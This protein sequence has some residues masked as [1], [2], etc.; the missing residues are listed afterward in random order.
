MATAW[1]S[2]SRSGPQ[3]GGLYDLRPVLSELRGHRSR[4]AH[5]HAAAH[6]PRRE[7]RRRQR[8]PLHL[9]DW[10]IRAGSSAGRTCSSHLALAAARV[11]GSDW[12][13][14]FAS[15]TIRYAGTFRSAI[16]G[17]GPEAVQPSVGGQRVRPL[18]A[19]L[20][21]GRRLSARQRAD[22][23]RHVER[24][25]PNRD[26]AAIVGRIVGGSGHA[27]PTAARSCRR[28]ASPATS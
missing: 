27:I 19:R 6:A 16:A 21:R 1:S 11:S 9:G 28:G 18:L 26:R 15:R 4:D 13:A 20:G 3:P 22:P 2:T 24:T 14:F 7:R 23:A 10:A 25:F 12:T 5:Q 17:S 8:R